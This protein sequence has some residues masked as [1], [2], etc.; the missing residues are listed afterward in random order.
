[1]L[2]DTGQLG[3]ILGIWAHPDDDA[4]SSAGLM[5]LALQNGQK[6]TIVCATKGDAGQTCDEAKWP[7]H[8]LAR[9]RKQEQRAALKELGK[10]KLHWLK[11]K[12]GKLHQ[13]NQDQAVE[14]LV[15]YIR[16]Y[17][18]DSVISFGQDGITGHEDHK[19]IHVWAKQAA[20]QENV[21]FYGAKLARQNQEEITTLKECDK[22]FNIFFNIAEPDILKVEQTDIYLDLNDELLRIKLNCLSKHASQTTDLLRNKKLATCLSRVEAFCKY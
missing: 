3:D 18:P 17:K 2:N 11:F 21:E 14:Q 9:I 20:K 13:V 22:K 5:K 15:N 8:K 19:T 12:D 10:I 4:F 16:K 6:V 1:M 7:Q